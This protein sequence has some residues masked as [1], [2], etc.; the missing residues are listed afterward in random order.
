[1]TLNLYL[2]FSCILIGL[3]Q[4]LADADV[5]ADGPQSWFHGFPGSEDGHA[6]YLKKKKGKKE[7]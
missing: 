5:F 6:C 2:W 4:D 3:D 7:N 1:M